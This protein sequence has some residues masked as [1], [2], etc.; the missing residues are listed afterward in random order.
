MQAVILALIGTI[1]LIIPAVIA[2]GS[3]RGRR[4]KLLREEV[5]LLKDLPDH[6]G[7]EKKIARL[8]LRESLWAYSI[9]RLAPRRVG[10]AM[11]YAIAASFAMSF[12]ATFILLGDDWH[13]RIITEPDT[14]PHWRLAGTVLFAAG[15]VVYVGT[16]SGLGRRVTEGV[17]GLGA[18]PGVVRRAIA[19][20]AQQLPEDLMA[21]VCLERPDLNA[22]RSVSG[23]ITH[24]LLRDAWA[25]FEK[26]RNDV[27]A[28]D[29]NAG[30][31]NLTC[32]GSG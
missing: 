26:R 31:S 18:D 13:A 25:V 5:A 30:R 32:T 19:L 29:E 12:G 4:L 24:R 15:A 7:A 8:V 2:L 10:A 27:T 28:T 22:D 1:G 14:R 11:A 20:E 6:F 9:D 21:I 23:R 17:K 16:V 3:A